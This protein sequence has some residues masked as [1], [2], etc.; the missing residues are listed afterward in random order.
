MIFLDPK[1]PH[2]SHEWS[3][4]TTPPHPTH[5]TLLLSILF[6]LVMKQHKQF[7]LP[8]S[9]DCL[10]PLSLLIST[11][12]LSSIRISYVKLNSWK[13]FYIWS[14]YVFIVKNT[15]VIGKLWSRNPSP[16]NTILL[17][18]FLD[19][20]SCSP[21]WPGTDSNSES[22]TC[23]LWVLLYRCAPPHLVYMVLILS[24]SGQHVAQ[25]TF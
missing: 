15:S 2:L 23:T 5:F 25:Q 20:I 10:F 11:N 18:S 1:A 19:R 9:F 13:H 3:P 12:M 6:I 24:N 4:L 7:S 22:L 8:F 17:F 14:S 16:I 21:C